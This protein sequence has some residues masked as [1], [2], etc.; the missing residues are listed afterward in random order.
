MPIRLLPAAMAVLGVLLASGAGSARSG[1]SPVVQDWLSALITKIDDADRAQRSSAAHRTAGTV[2][3]HVQVA[4][5]GS[6]RQT[7][8]ERS[9]G[10]RA[11]DQ[12]A[13]D[14][15]QAASPFTAPPPE[16]LTETG[17]TDL[18]F[19]ISLER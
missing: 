4:A 5:D 11:V 14:A 17:V 1:I 12:R 19:P 2:V 16:L 18:S 13:L 7:D 6:I 3:V 9:S 15:V 10:S 8:I